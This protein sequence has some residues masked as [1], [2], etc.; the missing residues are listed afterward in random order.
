[1][2]Y[3]H[4]KIYKKENGAPPDHKRSEM[5]YEA[6]VNFESLKKWTAIQILKIFAVTLRPDDQILHHG[7]TNDFIYIDYANNERTVMV[8][9]ERVSDD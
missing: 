9:V 7:V 8:T 4:K 1:M 3:F 2:I 6:D 5:G